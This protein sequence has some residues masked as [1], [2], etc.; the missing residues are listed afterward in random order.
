MRTNCSFFVLD[1]LVCGDAIPLQDLGRVLLYFDAL[2]SAEKVLL[3][4]Y[5]YCTRYKNKI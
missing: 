2:S 4:T 5:L 3:D 1:D